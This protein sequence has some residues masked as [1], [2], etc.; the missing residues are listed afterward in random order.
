MDA[1]KITSDKNYYGPDM[2]TVINEEVEDDLNG[3]VFVNELF[4]ESD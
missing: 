2:E 1:T 4:T 3:K